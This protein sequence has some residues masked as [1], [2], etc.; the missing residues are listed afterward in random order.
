[1]QLDHTHVLRADTGLLVDFASRVLR[2]VEASVGDQ[3]R[4][5]EGDHRVG[6]HR[7]GED[8]H[9]AAQAV[10][11]GELLGN[12]Q[13]GGGAAGRRAGHQTGHHARPHEL[14]VHHVFGGDDVLEQRQR[15]V[16]GVTAGL[17]ANGGEGFHLGAVLLHV[18]AAGTTE[19]AQG[20][21]QVGDIGGQ[22]FHH[23]DD[24]GAGT[25]T[26]I[27]VGFQGAGLHLLEA[28]RQGAIDLAALHGGTG[29]V[30]GSG[31]G[32][33]VVVDVDYRDTG[34]AHFVESGLAAGGVTVYVAGERHLYLVVAQAGIL[35]RQAH[36]FGAHVGV[37]RAGARL[38]E[39]DHADAGN[40]NFLAHARCSCSNAAPGRTYRPYRSREPGCP[41]ATPLGAV[42]SRTAEVPRPLTQLSRSILGTARLCSDRRRDELEEEPKASKWTRGRV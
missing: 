38:G 15:V 8:H 18:L 32:G 40:D 19:G 11:L 23:V 30:Q 12:D 41:G 7:L 22:V 5:I 21:R 39:G 34:A 20:L 28:Q 17:G 6:G 14:V 35:Q 37:A 16:G 10:L 3:R 36:G 27:P 25:R 2:H 31:A 33:A 9:V 24:A 13:R 42:C 29:Q 1:M 4:R 26:V